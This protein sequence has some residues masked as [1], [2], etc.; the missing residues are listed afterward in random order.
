MT[1][2]LKK[3]KRK[4]RKKMKR[5]EEGEEEEEEEQKKER[6][7]KA[8][9]GEA[10]FSSVVNWTERPLETFLAPHFKQP[11]WLFPLSHFYVPFYLKPDCKYFYHETCF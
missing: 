5:K 7:S 1:T 2:Y 3:G 4:K 9:L 8:R 11:V 10:C 6:V